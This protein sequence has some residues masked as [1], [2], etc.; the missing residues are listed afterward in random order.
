[1]SKLWT[2]SEVARECKNCTLASSHRLKAQERQIAAL[3]REN[4]RLRAEL[5]QWRRQALEEDAVANAIRRGEAEGG[6][7]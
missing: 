6:R 4:I 5:E 1:M 7:P 2:S 3:R